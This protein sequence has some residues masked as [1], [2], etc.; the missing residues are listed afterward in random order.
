MPR[1]KRLRLGKEYGVNPVDASVLVEDERVADYFEQVMTE[2]RAW[3]ETLE[4]PMGTT[5]EIW[6]LNKKRLTKLVC[7]WLLSE[8]FKLMNE[9]RE[10]ILDIKISPENF[11]E[12]IALVYRRK[13]NSSA[14]QIILQ[15]MYKTGGDPSDIMAEEDLVQIDDEG[16]IEQVVKKILNN[17]PEQVAEY[18]HG[19]TPLLKYFVGLGMKEL[20]GKAN[21]E[22]LSEMFLSKLK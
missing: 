15:K 6:E 19:K 12:F 16:Q 17:N 4:D 21:P 11:A 2:A 1:F 7:G 13:V 18:L 10:S 20:K 22:V 9:A 5:E 14:A 3:L 8:L